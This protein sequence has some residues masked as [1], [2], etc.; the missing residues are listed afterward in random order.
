MCKSRYCNAFKVKLLQLAL[1]TAGLATPAASI[2]QDVYAVDPATLTPGERERLRE[3][4]QSVSS[5]ELGVGH[6]NGDA[7]KFGDYSGLHREGY[8]LIG[9]MDL[10]ERPKPG[11]NDT[12]YLRIQG[13]NLGLDSRN[14]EVEAGSQGSYRLRVEHD[15][16]PKKQT[17]KYLTIYEGAGT[18]ALTLPAGWVAGANTGA[19]PGLT[20]NLR[21]FEVESARTNVRLGVNK[22]LDGRW[23]GWELD[24][25]FRREEKDGTKLMGSYNSNSTTQLIP[26]PVHYTTDQVELA[27]AYAGT[28]AQFQ[29]RYEMSTFKN[30]NRLLDWQSAFT[31]AQLDNRRD[32]PPENQFHQLNFSGGY[33]FTR[34][35]RF[36]AAASFGRMTQDEQFLAMSVNNPAAELPRSS[37]QGKVNTRHVNLGLSA[38]PLP[39]LSLGAGYRYYDRDNSTPQDVFRYIGRDGAGAQPALTSAFARVN[40]P[41][42][43]TRHQSKLDAAYEVL[44]RTK[45]SL[46]Y[47]LDEIQR[48]W[49]EVDKTRERSTRAE[50]RRGV[51]ETVTGGVGYERSERRGGEYVFNHPFVTGQ[52]P[53]Y[54]ATLAP[55]AQLDNNPAL[56]KFFEANRDRDRV[57]GFVS[58]SPNERVNL[59]FAATRDHDTYPDSE[60]GLTRSRGNT[61][62]IDGTYTPGEHLSLSAFYSRENSRLAQRG[63]RWTSTT[64]PT[65]G[66]STINAADAGADWEA[67][68]GYRTD[69][70]GIG[71]RAKPQ[72]RLELG[73]DAAYSRFT[74]D[75]DVSA[76][77]FETLPITNRPATPTALPMLV[78]RMASFQLSATYKVKDDLSIRG[79][80][81]FQ[82]LKSSDWGY[83]GL[84][85]TTV[86][87]ALINEETP[88][89]TVHVVGVSMIHKFR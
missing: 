61:Y 65:G 36:T 58:Y 4:T 45:L 43:Y 70:V 86:T 84:T 52:T 49:W 20:D 41:R 57:R 78:T 87:N 1:V 37:L 27:V 11:S 47:E 23:A 28:R 79:V 74:G 30:A 42:S 26:E 67:E 34:T 48:D 14:I 83:D 10:I 62:T 55:Q 22:V 9:N 51:S 66:A 81:W 32:L 6:V 82:R 2:A 88:Q 40:Q 16:L 72:E 68:M 39:K 38:R 17:D 8:H 31:G 35:T 80:Y 85:P 75:I 29:A 77:G 7:F 63:R 33:N 13:R 89:Y 53:E 21:P 76:P 46:G 56:R 3:L 50:I 71:L 60:L 15:E 25:K 59:Q 18:S 69:T 64:A 24:A 19:M 12:E 5:V 44:P 54:L 73:V